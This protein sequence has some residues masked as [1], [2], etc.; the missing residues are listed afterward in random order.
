MAVQNALPNATQVA[1]RWHLMENASHAFLD[2]VRKSM[3]QI[4]AAIGA[5]KIDPNLLTAAEKLQYEGYLR[6]EETNGVMER[7]RS[8][9]VASFAN[10]VSNDKRPSAPPS[11]LRGPTDKPKVRSPSSSLSSARCMDAASWTFCK[12]AS[13]A[14]SEPSAIKSASEPILD[15]DRGSILRVAGDCS[16]REH[17]RRVGII[18]RRRS[19]PVGVAL[20]DLGS[21]YAR[22]YA[23]RRRA[24]GV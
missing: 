20:C 13:L 3:R 17:S 9:L 15:A 23:R 24:R 10:G 16:G 12:P 6:R 18:A 11:L 7:A 4:R 5:A 19:C 22:E 8:S 2:A 1:D 21:L 14:Q